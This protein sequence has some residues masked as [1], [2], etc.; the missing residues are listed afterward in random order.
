M[1]DDCKCSQEKST[2]FSTIFSQNIVALPFYAYHILNN[3]RPLL[4]VSKN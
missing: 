4:S 3:V 1:L 2:T